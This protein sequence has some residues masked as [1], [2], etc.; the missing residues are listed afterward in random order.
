MCVF[1]ITLAIT[2]LPPT[3]RETAINKKSIPVGS[4]A[5]KGTSGLTKS[6]KTGENKRIT[7]VFLPINNKR[8]LV[9]K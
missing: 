5:R 1:S 4:K 9:L 2:K 6:V 8:P 3:A 7:S